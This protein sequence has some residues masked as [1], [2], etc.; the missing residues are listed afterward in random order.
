[1]MPFKDKEDY[2]NYQRTYQKQYKKTDKGKAIQDKYIKS[3]KRKAYQR[4]WYQKNKNHVLHRKK[5]WRENNKVHT[6]SYQKNY[7]QK[8]KEHERLY[9]KEY[10]KT[11]KY[12]MWKRPYM[13][14]YHKN[15][16]NID[17]GFLIEKRLRGLLKQYLNRYTKTGKIMSSKKYGI[18]WQPMVEKLVKT[19]PSDFKNNPSGWHIDHIRP[20]CSFDLTYPEQIKQCFSAD[21]LQWLTAEENMSKAGKYIN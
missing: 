4:A 5:I 12:R 1:M 11:E 17:M 13:R 2:R 9:K 20:C 18:E 6:K 3:E 7:R 19:L 8:N 21:N 14:T 15:R 10:F 16:C